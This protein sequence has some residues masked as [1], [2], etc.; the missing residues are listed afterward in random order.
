MASNP[1]LHPLTY[2]GVDDQGISDGKYS[3]ERNSKSPWFWITIGIVSVVVIGATV[4]GS[5]GGTIAVRNKSCRTANISSVS[6]LPTQTVTQIQRLPSSSPIPANC[7]TVNGTVYN[8]LYTNGN[9]TFQMF[10]GKSNPGTVLASGFFYTF[11]DCI[12]LCSSFNYWNNAGKC[13]SVDYIVSDTRPTNCW[14]HNE[15]DSENDN[16]ESVTAL[17]V[18]S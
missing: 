1:E 3:G 14:A 16:A 9:Q 18:V 5:I 4:G 13:I 8:S 12:E 15:I 11:E 6:T 10:C 2:L 17:L 7:P